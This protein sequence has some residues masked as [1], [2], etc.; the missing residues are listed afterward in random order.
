MAFW[1]A[2]LPLV[3]SEEWQSGTWRTLEYADGSGRALGL[4]LSDSPPEPRP[5]LHL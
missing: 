3:A 4:L 1:T 5:R 2:A